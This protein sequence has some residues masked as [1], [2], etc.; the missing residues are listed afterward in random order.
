MKFPRILKLKKKTSPAAPAGVSIEQQWIYL[1]LIFVLMV[2]VLIG[3][4][5]YVFLDIQDEDMLSVSETGGRRVVD[6][7]L[8]NETVNIYTEKNRLFE[9]YKTEK[10]DAPAI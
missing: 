2:L 3:V 4:D 6:E 7:T 1:L 8:L 10:P 5:T 9:M